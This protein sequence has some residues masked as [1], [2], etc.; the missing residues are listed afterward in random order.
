MALSM[1]TSGVTEDDIAAVVETFYV[2][3]RQ[4][5]LLGP[6][7]ARAIADGAWPA[8]LSV[9]RDFWS[10]VMLKTRRYQRNPFSAH[11]RVEGIRPE[12]FDQWLALFQ[13][14]C[15]ELLA[16]SPAEALYAKAV[17]IGDSLKA[18]LFVRPGAVA[19]MPHLSR[20]RKDVRF[21]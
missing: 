4:D 12:L 14:T 9:I 1:E 3:V 21:S 2:K 17:M 10:S 15:N 13:E 7:F 18:G 19:S 11:V 16:P 8:H 6:V 20:A 5:P